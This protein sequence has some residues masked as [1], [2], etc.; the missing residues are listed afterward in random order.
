MSYSW[1][2][3]AKQDGSLRKILD[4]EQHNSQL[5]PLRNQEYGD[6]RIRNVQMEH[7][8]DDYGR[9]IV[10]KSLVGIYLKSGFPGKEDMLKKI[11]VKIFSH[12]AL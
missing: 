6:G 3:S 5:V 4:L 9:R 2:S 12:G 11:T 8:G 7:H 1:Q 10:L